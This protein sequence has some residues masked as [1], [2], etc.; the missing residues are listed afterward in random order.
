MPKARVT[1]QA[2]SKARKQIVYYAHALCLYRRPQERSE[3]RIIR[4]AFP[5]CKVVNPAA[6]ENDTAKK[7]DTLGFCLGLVEK[8]DGLVFTRLLGKVTAGVGEE[9]AHALKHGRPVYELKEFVDDWEIIRRTRPV[10]FVSRAETIVL[11]RLF[12][13]SESDVT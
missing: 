5:G 4:R 9:I 12:R 3:L 10:K 11:Y 2:G 1:P 7:K 6:Y 8:C 13:A